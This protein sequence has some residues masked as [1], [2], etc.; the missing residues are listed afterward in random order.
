VGIRTIR[1]LM[2]ALT[3]ERVDGNEYEECGNR[4]Q[5]DDDHLL[6][7]LV[8]VHFFDLRPHTAPSSQRNRPRNRQAP[9]RLQVIKLQSTGCCSAIGEPRMATAIR[10]SNRVPST[11]PF[12]GWKMHGEE[13]GSIAQSRSAPNRQYEFAVGSAREP[14]TQKGRNRCRF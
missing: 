1:S 6:A 8:R 14:L 2:S 9:Q 11:A 12:T 10:G 4:S 13:L 5:C 7:A 3:C